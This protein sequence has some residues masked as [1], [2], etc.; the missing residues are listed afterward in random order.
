LEVPEGS[1]R[2]IAGI[3]P[4]CHVPSVRCIRLEGNRIRSAVNPGVHFQYT[5]IA[6]T[7]TQSIAGGA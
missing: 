4:G 6:V 2:R 3:I 5:G 1:E 7:H